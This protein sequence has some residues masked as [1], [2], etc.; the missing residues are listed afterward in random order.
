MC[1]RMNLPQ[2]V[3]RSFRFVSKT[4]RVCVFILLYIRERYTI[5]VV[6]VFCC[7]MYIS[8]ILIHL[9]FYPRLIIL[10]KSFCSLFIYR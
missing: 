10:F 7:S 9:D 2:Q 8:E 4:L 1:L 5:I 3:I 6:V